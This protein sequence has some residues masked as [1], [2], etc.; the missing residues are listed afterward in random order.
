LLVLVGIGGGPPHGH[1][2]W[3]RSQRT[4]TRRC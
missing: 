3:R 1:P 4:G 2:W